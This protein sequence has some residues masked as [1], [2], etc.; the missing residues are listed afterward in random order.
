ML[1]NL[2]PLRENR[3]Y[4]LLFFGQLVSFLGSMVSYVAVP[5][6]IYDL[7]KDNWMVGLLGL[8][9][10]GP[11]LVFGILGGTYADRLNRRRLLLWS[12][13]LMS[14]LIFG[15]ALNAFRAEPSVT[16]TFILV[17]LFQ[18][19][20]GF[21][22]P[23]MDALTQKLVER[24]DYAAVGALGSF[25]YT[26][27]AIAGP[28]L[29]GIL[30]A[31]FGVKGAYLFDFFTFLAALVALFLMKKIPDPELSARSPWLDAKE[32]LRYALSKPELIGTYVIDIV[33]M[34]FAFPVALFPAMSEQWG[35]AKAAGLLFSAM[36]V[37]A[38]LMTITSGWTS[39]VSRH[40]RGVVVAALLWA[41]FMI[42]VGLTD[43]L[44]VALLFLALAGG[45]DMMS[46]LFRSIIWNESVPNELRGRLSGIEM[47]SYMSGPLLGNARAGWMAA[48]F[49][50]PISLS[51]GGIVC[52]LMVL[53]TAVFLP[54]FW[55]YQGHYAK[56]PS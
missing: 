34:V 43:Q 28:A 41:V 4:R 26:V 13:S 6:Q 18:S 35:G 14:L 15:L 7:T 30:I 51:G 44:W 54:R 24:K 22:R 45:A 2:R 10:L 38:L 27:G 20:V 16:L 3:E 31:G 56:G 50:I 33:A 17:A 48:Q 23:A 5:Y 32:G 53:L 12:E 21:H 25:R 8:V 11:V 49:S 9:Q 36:A 46:G 1:L 40:G 55:K 42:G 52:T 47:I 29:G 39:R 37:G 19:V